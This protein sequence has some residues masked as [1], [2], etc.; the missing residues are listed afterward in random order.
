[1]IL[2]QF[3]DPFELTCFVPP[4]FSILGLLM[5]ALHLS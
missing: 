3:L 5:V 2:F 1:M 4:D